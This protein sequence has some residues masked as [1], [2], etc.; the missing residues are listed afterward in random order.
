MK[1]IILMIVATVLLTSCATIFTGT[2]TT[3]KITSNLEEADALTVDGYTYRNVK[4]PFYLEMK[5]GF[6]SSFIDGKK[7]GCEEASVIVNKRFNPVSVLNLF[8]LP[9]WAIDA[10]T[11]A[12]T[13]PEYNIYELYFEEV[14]SPYPP[15]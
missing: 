14:P 11:G 3:V 9:F 8:S 13:V 4:F 1:R 2:Q 6:Y 7:K 12:I 5:G 15:K 10:A